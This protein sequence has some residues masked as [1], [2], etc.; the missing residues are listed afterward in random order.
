V[1]I[2]DEDGPSRGRRAER[3]AVTLALAGFESL[4]AADL[5]GAIREL[6]RHLEPGDVLVTLGAG[7]VGTIAD[8]FLRRLSRDRH[9]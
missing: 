3:L 7:D 4:R 5:D 9:D 8:A 6:D 1:L 2:I